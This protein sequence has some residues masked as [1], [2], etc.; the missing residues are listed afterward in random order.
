MNWCKAR[1][2]MRIR[3]TWATTSPL[4][5]ICEPRIPS[6]TISSSKALGCNFQAIVLDFHLYISQNRACLQRSMMHEGSPTTVVR[7][8]STRGIVGDVI[9]ITREERVSA[10]RISLACRSNRIFLAFLPWKVRAGYFSLESKRAPLIV[11]QNSGES[12]ITWQ[13]RDSSWTVIHYYILAAVLWA[14]SF[15]INSWF[16]GTSNHVNVYKVTRCCGPFR[17]PSFVILARLLRAYDQ[18]WHRK[19]H[20]RLQLEP[21]PRKPPLNLVPAHHR[22]ELRL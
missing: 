12:E 10:I 7:L 18:P 17:V 21:N 22:P 6:G 14:V 16:L 11:W 15:Q 9:F 3:M 1:N 8:E 13:N 4:K 19:E 20:T 5:E 2:G